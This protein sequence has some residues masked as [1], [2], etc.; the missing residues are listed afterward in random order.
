M[1]FDLYFWLYN[2]LSL[3]IGECER[4]P[5]DKYALFVFTFYILIN[6]KHISALCFGQT[7]ARPVVQAKL[8]VTD[9]RSSK[10]M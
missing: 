8:I 5:C 7:G 6:R 4:I 9:I 3:Y 1:C 2:T 10:C